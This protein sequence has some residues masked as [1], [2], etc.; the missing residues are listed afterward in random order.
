MKLAGRSMASQV[1]LPAALEL[2]AERIWVRQAPGVEYSPIVLC[3]SQGY[4]VNLLRV[5]RSGVLSSHRHFG[6]VHAFTLKGT[7]YYEEHPWRAQ[8]GDYVYEPPGELHTLIVPQDCPE[9]I[10]LFHVTGGYSY[11]GKDGQLTGFEGVFT[12]LAALETHCRSAGLP[13][14]TLDRFIR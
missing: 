11:V 5:T 12:K 8:P 10:T 13:I 1:Y 7:W 4:Y 3:A 2:D 6:P 14:S 9:M